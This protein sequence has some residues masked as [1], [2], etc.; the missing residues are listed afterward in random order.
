MLYIGSSLL[1]GVAM[2]IIAEKDREFLRGRFEQELDRPVTITLFTRK[3]KLLVPG[4]ECLYCDDT[5][6]L[7]EEVAS[8]S[9]KIALE[10]KD[11]Y[12]EP[13]E[14]ARFGADKVPF[15]VFHA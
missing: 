4:Q 15:L 10:V 7:M 1:A 3:S 5:E 12:S 14:A 6:R 8:L 13:E 11:F 9:D 2:P